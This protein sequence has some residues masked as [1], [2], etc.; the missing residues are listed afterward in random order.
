MMVARHRI[1]PRRAWTVN[2][3]RGPGGRNRADSDKVVRAISAKPGVC[4]KGFIV[5][6]GYSAVNPRAQRFGNLTAASV[7]Q[8]SALG[9]LHHLIGRYLG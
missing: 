8:G 3:A 1:G 6:L 4:G 5:R 9:N 7:S 2:D